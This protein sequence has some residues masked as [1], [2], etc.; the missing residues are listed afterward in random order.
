MAKLLKRNIHVVNLDPA[1]ETFR[2]TTI[3]NIKDLVSCED[4]MEFTKLGPNGGLIYSMEYL[5][6]N[7][8]WFEDQLG[9]LGVDDYVLFDCP[10]QLELYTHLDIMKKVVNCL[11]KIGFRLCSVCLVDST[12]LSDEPKFFSG[13]LM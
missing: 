3:V 9:D 6:E 10:G 7:M 1:A 11:Q 8:D 12:F 5:I 4:V 2:Y 13:V